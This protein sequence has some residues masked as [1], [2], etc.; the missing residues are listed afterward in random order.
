MRN[1][2]LVSLLM[3]LPACSFFKSD[4]KEI[5]SIQEVAT[6]FEQAHQDDLVI[7]DVDDTLTYNVNVPFQP[8]FS[9]T[10]AGKKFYAQ[11]E[12]HGR[13]KDDQRDYE[14]RIRGARMLKFTDQPIEPQIVE[15]I[16]E[17]VEIEKEFICESLPCSLI[18][19]NKTL[20]SQYIEYVADRLITQLNYRKIYNSENPFDF[21]NKTNLDGKSNFFEK[22]V[23]EYALASGSGDNVSNKLDFGED[24]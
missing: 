6:I 1:Y 7:F 12:K 24:F 4:I 3:L 23:T 10:D 19:M 22:R 20:M 15:I 9:K 18:G 2:F 5:N 8:W 17:A 13:S 11:L 14:K 21:M 16:K